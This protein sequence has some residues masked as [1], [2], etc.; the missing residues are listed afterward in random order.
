M[1]ERK[2]TG[3]WKCINVFF[4]PK[5]PRQLQIALFYTQCKNI[6]VRWENSKI[7][8]EEIL[9]FYSAKL[10]HETFTKQMES[11]GDQMILECMDSQNSCNMGTIN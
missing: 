2:K 1:R 11:K 4:P 10:L 3:T 8:N 5:K 9:E 7:L 6:T